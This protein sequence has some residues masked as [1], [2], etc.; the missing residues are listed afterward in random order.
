MFIKTV[1]LTELNCGSVQIVYF[2]RKYE[3][4]IYQNTELLV[5]FYAS[6]IEE[7]DNLVETNNYLADNGD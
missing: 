4:Y 2:Q 1:G 7:L 6:N 3:L 5:V